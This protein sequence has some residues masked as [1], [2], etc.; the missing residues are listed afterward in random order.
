MC[1]A[2]VY[3]TANGSPE[4]VAEDVIMLEEVPQGVRLSTFFDEPQV[5]RGRVRRVDFLKHIVDLVPVEEASD[6]G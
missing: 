2:K 1:Q 4:L 3:L 5:V 6:G